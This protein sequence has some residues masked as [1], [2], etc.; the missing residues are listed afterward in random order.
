MTC[1]ALL[2]P[3][4]NK[5]TLKKAVGRTVSTS[6]EFNKLPSPISAVGYTGVYGGSVL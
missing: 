5:V 1:E 6:E 3:G 2:K 4:N